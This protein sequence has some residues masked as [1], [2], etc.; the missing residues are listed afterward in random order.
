MAD[1][2]PPS[3]SN[4]S[5]QR[6]ADQNYPSNGLV[7][8]PQVIASQHSGSSTG[9]SEDTHDQPPSPA[10]SSDQQPQKSETKPQATFLTKLYAHV[11]PSQH[12]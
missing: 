11:S 3:Y 4:R 12:R 6:H 10:K 1:L 2:Y 7:Y 5:Y 8:P 9:S